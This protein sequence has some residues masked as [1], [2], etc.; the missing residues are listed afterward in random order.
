[1]SQ[2]KGWYRLVTWEYFGITY[3]K[4]IKRNSIVLGQKRQPELF[5]FLFLFQTSAYVKKYFSD[6]HLSTD[7][8][9]I[10]CLQPLCKCNIYDLLFILQLNSV[11]VLVATGE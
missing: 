1:L 6:K 5:I 7:Y 9:N 8:L 10:A 4:I 11:T 3:S 2:F